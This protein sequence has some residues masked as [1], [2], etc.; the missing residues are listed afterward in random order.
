MTLIAE[1]NLT[2]D[3]GSVINAGASVTIQGDQESTLPSGS[4]GADI[5]VAGTITGTSL[6]I[7]GGSHNDMISLTGVQANTPTTI[8]TGTGNDT[9]NIGSHATAISNTGG[10]LGT[11]KDSLTI[12]GQGGTDTLNIDDTG[13]ATART[14]EL[15][16]TTLTGLDMTNGHYLLG[17]RDLE[18]CPWFRRGYLHHPSR[19]TS[20]RRT[21]TQAQAR[22]RSMSGR[23]TGLPP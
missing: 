18:Y 7:E 3:S 11:I 9:I 10:V 23:S 16:S 20:P 22:T 15:T 4:T 1:Q 13:D 6:T 19:R 8:E 14:G 12:D 5:Q 21:S 2:I 17:N